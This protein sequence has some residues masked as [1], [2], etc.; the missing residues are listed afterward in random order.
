MLQRKYA[1][2]PDALMPRL[3]RKIQHQAMSL[4]SSKMMNSESKSTHESKAPMSIYDND[5][6]IYGNKIEKYTLVGFPLRTKVYG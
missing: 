5:T 3:F 6:S 4:T 1:K 2:K